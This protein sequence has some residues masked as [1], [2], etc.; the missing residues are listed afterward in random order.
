[1]DPGAA[2]A[3]AACVPKQRASVSPA[4][5]PSPLLDRLRQLAASGTIVVAHRGDSCNHPENTLPAFAAAAAAGAPMQEFDVQQTR[6]GQL[7]CLHDP[8]LD[9]TTDATQRLGPGAMV[10]QSDLAGLQALDAGAWKGAAHRGTRIPTLAEALAAMRPSVPM[11]EHKGG[12]AGVFV[13]ELRRLGCLDAV[14]LQS[15]EWQ[16]VA[17]AAALAPELALGLLGPT[18]AAPRLDATVIAAASRIGAAFVHWHAPE[19]HAEGVQRVHDAGLLLCTYT[20]D[21]ELEWLGGEVLGIDAMCTN[22][23][24]RMLAGAGSRAAISRSRS[25]RSAGSGRT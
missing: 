19:V 3:D 17:A 23:P 11:I 6:D 14:L 16:F 21:S 4:N 2:A 15:F 18:A 25:R 24:S 12:A 10:A 5:R 20:S 13:A 9:R 22:D 1:M 8:T 7:V